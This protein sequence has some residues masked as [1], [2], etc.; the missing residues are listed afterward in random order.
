MFVLLCSSLKALLHGLTLGQMSPAPRARH[1]TSCC[2]VSASTLTAHEYIQS[3]LQSKSINFSAVWLFNMDSKQ[4]PGNPSLLP[5]LSLW[6][7]ADAHFAHSSPQC[8]AS[9]SSQVFAPP[10]PGR[11]ALQL[12][13]FL[14]HL[15]IVTALLHQ[16]KAVSLQVQNQM[17]A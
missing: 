10:H 13:A 16:A 7:P 9:A 17:L 3:Q 11:P 8:R 15:R 6:L 5:G 14:K 1:Y 4:F 12:A 2:S